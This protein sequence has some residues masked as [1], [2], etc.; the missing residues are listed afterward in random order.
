MLENDRP[1]WGYIKGEVLAAGRSGVGAVAGQFGYV[2]LTNPLN[3]GVLATVESLNWQFG[4]SH[5]FVKLRALTAAGAPVTS[6]VRDSRWMPNGGVARPSCLVSAGTSGAAAPEPQLDYL[7]PTN[8]GE[9]NTAYTLRPG[10]SLWVELE[11]ANITLPTVT[12]VWRERA[13]ASGELG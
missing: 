10:T 12:Y 9:R 2:A 11:V 6:G 5:G 1:E 4:A 7:F 8:Y 13:A 3:S